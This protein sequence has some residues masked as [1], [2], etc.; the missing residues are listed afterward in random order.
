MK[1]VEDD[2]SSLL[3][4]FDHDLAFLEANLGGLNFDEFDFDLGGNNTGDVDALLN[5]DGIDFDEALRS[6]ESGDFDMTDF[7]SP[8]DAA[9]LSVDDFSDRQSS[10]SDESSNDSSS[11]S[12]GDNKGII[13]ADKESKSDGTEID[14][15]L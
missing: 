10:G 3:P 11:G 6:I 2:L 9:S 8:E 1:C 5:E 12:S 13:K 7:L 15:K 14:S 4:N